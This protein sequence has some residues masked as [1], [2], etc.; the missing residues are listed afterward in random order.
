MA[1][2]IQS[3]FSS[4]MTGVSRKITIQGNKIWQVINRSVIML[5]YYCP[6]M[7]KDVVLMVK[8][9]KNDHYYDYTKGFSELFNLFSYICFLQ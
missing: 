8:Y 2:L 4:K 9:N 3:K 5:L 7:L 6:S 1:L